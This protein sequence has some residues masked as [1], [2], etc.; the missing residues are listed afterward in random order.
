MIILYDD[1]LYN[2]N[3]THNEYQ[4]IEN[5]IPPDLFYSETTEKVFSEWE[6]K[7]TL[8]I[9]LIFLIGFLITFIPAFKRK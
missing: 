8:R 3:L 4:K 5:S 1:K 9:S 2:I 7:M 6:I